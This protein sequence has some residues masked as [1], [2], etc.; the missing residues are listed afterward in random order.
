M[1]IG[2]I[3][4]KI[5]EILCDLL[6]KQGISPEDSLIGKS[7]ILDSITAVR[8]INKIEEHF[9]INILEEDLCLEGLKN[10]H[11]LSQMVKSNMK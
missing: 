7:G 9:K 8:L 5:S 11:S 3:E 2:E 1:E 10:I 4:K 6:G